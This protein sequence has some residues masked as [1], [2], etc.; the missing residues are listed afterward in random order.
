MGSSSVAPS[1]GLEYRF[2]WSAVEHRAFYRALQREVSRRSFLRFL[3]PGALGLFA[4]VALVAIVGSELSVGTVI[5]VLAPY[6]LLFFFWIALLKWGMAYV[7]ARMY[8]RAHAACIP[9]DQIRVIS[10]EGLE[11]RCVT[12]TVQVR[13]AGIVRTV[14]TA[15][16]FLFFTTPS[17]AIQLPKQAITDGASLERL[18]DVLRAHLGARAELAGPKSVAPAG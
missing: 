17:C 14:E 12:S 10:D 4:V 13:W 6:V 16:Y 15:D 2:R 3:V 9:H 11:A 5:V 1:T 18:R 8:R 7:S